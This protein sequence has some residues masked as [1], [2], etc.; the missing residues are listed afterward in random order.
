M[1]NGK[2]VKKQSPKANVSVL[3]VSV[4]LMLVLVIGGTLAWLS[5]QTEKIENTFTATYVPNTPEEEYE[6]NVKRSIV[7]KNDGNIDVYVRVK[8][9][10]YRVNDKSEPIGG[11]AEIPEFRLGERWVEYNGYYYYTTPVAPN[12]KTGNLIADANSGIELQEYTDADGG[13]QVIEVISESIQSVPEKAIGEAWG[14]AIAN[15]NVTEYEGG[16]A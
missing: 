13:K 2:R 11:T 14:V 5:T 6:N 4:L 16:N 12:G 1:Y 9:V 7:V 8:L 10:T 3:S 15:D